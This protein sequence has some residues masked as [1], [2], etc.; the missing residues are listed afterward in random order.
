MS[1]SQQRRR[2]VWL[3]TAAESSFAAD[4][5]EHERKVFARV[6]ITLDRRLV[7]NDHLTTE[8]RSRLLA[9]AY[10]SPGAQIVVALDPQRH[11]IPQAAQ[12]LA[13]AADQGA[14]IVFEHHDLEIAERWR[15]AV[16]GGGSW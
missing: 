2:N 11:V 16:R 5:S 6:R 14:S 9:L 4:S 13:V 12:M 10:I 15:A 7:E 8:G 1:Q 3:R